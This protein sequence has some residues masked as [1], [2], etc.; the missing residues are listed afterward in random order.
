MSKQAI[1]IISAGV[2]IAVFA[3]GSSAQPRIYTLGMSADVT[4]GG[5]GGNISGLGV[6]QNPN[7]N[8]ATYGSYPS[9]DFKSRSEHNTLDASYSWGFNRYNT[10]PKINSTSHGASFGF[11]TNRNGAEKLNVHISDQFSVSA[12]RQTFDL[13]RG[14]DLSQIPQE[15]RYL[16]N[17]VV[18]RSTRTNTATVGVDRTISTSG[19]LNFSASHSIVDYRGSNTVG[20]LSNQQRYSATAGYTHAVEHGAVNFYYGASRF[21]FS[22]FDNAW[23]HFASLGYSHQF[24]KELS[25]SVGAGA[26]FLQSRQTNGSRVGANASF[27]LQ[28]SVKNGAFSLSVSQASGDSSGFGSVST[29]RQAGFGIS[30]KYGKNLSVGSSVSGFDIRTSAGPELSSRGVAVGGTVGYNIARRWAMIAGGQYQKY[31]GTS[32]FNFNQR[33]LFVTFRFNNPEFWRFQG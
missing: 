28:R 1:H 2:L 20:V 10:D 19:S 16:F 6:L 18:V 15:F 22:D 25:M 5:S 23:S 9:L 8:V 17:P 14:L 30:H 21:Q 24:S 11:S 33:R 4:A 26:S 12:D 32:A 29:S 31:T 3:I 7:Q 27:G 13:L